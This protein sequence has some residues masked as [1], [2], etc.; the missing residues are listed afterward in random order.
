MVKKIEYSK[1]DTQNL[2]TKK[3]TERV[4]RVNAEWYKLYHQ[5]EKLE[6]RIS[7][8]G[9][10]SRAGTIASKKLKAIYKKM[11]ARA[12]KEQRVLRQALKDEDLADTAGQSA[13]TARSFGTD[14]GVDYGRG[15]EFGDDEEKKKR[16]I[17]RTHEVDRKKGK[18]KGGYV[19]KYA[20]GGGVRKVRS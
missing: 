20:K 18:A 8:A 19:K 3:E 2:V 13:P 17:R 16:P 1:R 6:D 7:E 9:K 4:N 10:G 12:A 11:D 15:L 5:S 14:R